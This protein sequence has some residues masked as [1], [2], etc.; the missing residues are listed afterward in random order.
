MPR[1]SRAK[2]KD[3][4]VDVDA[5]KVKRAPDIQW[6]KNPDW[7]YTLI[8]YLGDHVV[9]IRNRACGFAGY[10]CSKSA[11][12]T[13]RYLNILSKLATRP[14]DKEKGDRRCPAQPTLKPSL[15]VSHDITTHMSVFC[16]GDNCS[17]HKSCLLG[18]SAATRAK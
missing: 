17:R 14:H 10:K 12:C 16:G 3:C 5:P 8:A 15:T 4:D 2:P 11:I 6:A 9:E 13:Q 18:A 1:K 7:T